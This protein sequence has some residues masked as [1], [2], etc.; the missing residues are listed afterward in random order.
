MFR[1]RSILLYALLALLW[2][3]PLDAA[4]ENTGTRLLR[5]PT[6]SANQ[7]AFAYANNI[8]IVPRAGGMARRVTSFQGTTVNPKFSP[9]GASIARKAVSRA[10]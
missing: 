3:R 10:G 9:D 6:V 1:P 8:W 4:P 5:Q 2:L 7:I